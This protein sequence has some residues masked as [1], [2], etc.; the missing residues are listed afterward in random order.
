MGAFVLGILNTGCGCGPMWA[1]L[2][3]QDFSY[4]EEAFCTFAA[5]G[6]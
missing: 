5:Q 3:H 6:L 2:W 1:A 4:Q